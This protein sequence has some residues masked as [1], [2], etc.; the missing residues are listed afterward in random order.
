MGITT[1]LFPS[2]PTSNG[3]S[4]DSLDRAGRPNDTTEAVVLVANFMRSTKAPARTPGSLDSGNKNGQKA[5]SSRQRALNQGEQAFLNAGCGICHVATFV[6]LPAGT[7]INGG[8]YEVPAAL[9]SA[10][11]HPYSDFLL[12]D[13]GT[14]DGIVQ[15]GGQSTRNKIRTMPLWGLSKRRTFLHDGSANSI[16]EAI[17]RHSGEASGAVSA[18]Q[19]L[20]PQANQSVMSFLNSL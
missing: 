9:G 14:G 16:S 8:A 15:N 2:E 19:R 1:P 10:T 6:T 7:R 12:H 18:F 20:P 4:V 11:I 5:P 3:R 17:N 13:I